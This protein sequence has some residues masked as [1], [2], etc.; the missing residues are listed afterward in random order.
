[1]G[2]ALSMATFTD[3]FFVPGA[4]EPSPTVM[5]NPVSGSTTQDEKAIKL[6]LNTT[7]NEDM[8]AV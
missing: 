1:M 8:R 5:S 3:T 4:A 6:N 7:K 2:S